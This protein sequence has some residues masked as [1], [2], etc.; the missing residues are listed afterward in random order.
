MSPPVTIELLEAPEVV[1]AGEDVWLRFAVTCEPGQ[2]VSVVLPAEGVRH[3]QAKID[4]DF[5][6]DEVRLKPGDRASLSVG[7]H[8]AEPG[9]GDWSAFRVQVNPLTGNDADR[10]FV[11]LPKRPFRIT[12]SLDRCLQLSLARVCTYGDA[13]K[14][15]VVARNGCADDLTDLELE[16][17]PPE[18]VRMGPLKKCVA[19]LRPGDEVKFDLVVSAPSVAFAVNALVN[20]SRLQ[21]MRCHMVPSHEARLDA[22]AAFRFLEPR[23]LTTDRVTLAREKNGEELTPR[24]GLHPIRGGKSHYVLT[25]YPTRPEAIGVRLYKAPGRVEVESHPPTGRAWSFTI[26]IVENPMLTQLVRLDYD[27]E[28]PNDKALRGEIYL[29]IRP[30]WTKLW[31]VAATLGIT[32]TAKGFYELASAGTLLRLDDGIGA[33]AEHLPELLA[34]RGTKLLPLLSVPGFWLLLYA[35]DRVWRPIEEG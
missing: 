3:P 7:V 33:A 12:P 17:G 8:L 9:N 6:T 27:V 10:A 34:Q 16:V 20:G 30:T 22:P 5:M 4:T 2:S 23:A 14:V 1:A 24:N 29:S 15:E 31:G 11:N 32:L 19:V 18:S 25:I 26:T 35:A 13:A 28:L 21:G